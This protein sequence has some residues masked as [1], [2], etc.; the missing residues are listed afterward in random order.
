MM[1][2]CDQILYWMIGSVIGLILSIPI[3]ILMFNLGIFFVIN[4][5]LD[6]IFPPRY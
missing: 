3:I 4:E 5:F 6:K 1:L 2:T